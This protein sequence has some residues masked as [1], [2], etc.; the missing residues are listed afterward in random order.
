[1][2]NRR[3]SHT[4]PQNGCV[5][6]FSEIKSITLPQKKHNR[7]RRERELKIEDHGRRTRQIESSSRQFSSFT[8]LARKE[9]LGAVQELEK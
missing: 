4:G 3:Y 8:Q 7:S 6:I 5:G 9:A 2:A 1:M